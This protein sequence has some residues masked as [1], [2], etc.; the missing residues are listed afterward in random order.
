[1]RDNVRRTQSE[2]LDSSGGRPV[3]GEEADGVTAN[4]RVP[5]FERELAGEPV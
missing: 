2:S 3:T 1:M 5:G 4:H